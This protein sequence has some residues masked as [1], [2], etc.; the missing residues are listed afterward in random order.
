M[1]KKVN[2]ERLL[3]SKVKLIQRGPNQ[4][5]SQELTKG[6]LLLQE[7]CGGKNQLWGTGNNLP[8]INNALTSG[9]GLIKHDDNFE[10]RTARMFG[11]FR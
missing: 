7:L 8:Q 5:I 6:Q 2:L 4:A 11:V 1:A 9:E 3:K 10:R